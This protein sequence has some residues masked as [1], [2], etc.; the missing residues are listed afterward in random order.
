MS[1][2]IFDFPK[3]PHERAG[4]VIEAAKEYAHACEVFRAAEEA[5]SAARQAKQP[6]TWL[7]CDELDAVADQLGTAQKRVAELTL[8]LMADG[9][10][11]DLSE[12][13]AASIAGRP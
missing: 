5:L 2:E 9:S 4:A 11:Q 7:L 13:L 8:A 6:E 1:A 10:L 3:T 12:L